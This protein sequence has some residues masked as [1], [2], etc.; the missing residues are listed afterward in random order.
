MNVKRN[1]VRTIPDNFDTNTLLY[2]RDKFDLLSVDHIDTWDYPRV[3]ETK[4]GTINGFVKLSS[5]TITLRC[6]RCGTVKTVVDKKTIGCKEGPCNVAWKDYTGKRFGHLVA[7]E[8]VFTSIS[9]GKKPKWYWKC[10]CDCGHV[11][12]KT[13]H[14]LIIA[15]QTECGYCARK[16]VTEKNTLPDDLSKW[17]REYRVCKKNALV[18]GYDNTLTFEQFK[19]I[20]EQPCYYCGAAPQKRSTGLIKNGIDRF[21]NSIGYTLENCVPCCPMCNTIKMQ[22]DYDLLI[23]H[24][25][26]MVNLYKERSTT[27]SQE[28]TPKPVEMDSIKSSD[29]PDLGF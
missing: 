21:D 28:S 26:R 7:L 5:V 14:D 20:C 2:P 12:L 1:L 6:K 8:Y 16:K 24:L 27:I 13:S 23:P 4:H 17:H 22:H 15:K 29:Q 19:H 9:E 3:Y 11:Y 25:E 10:Q 18:R